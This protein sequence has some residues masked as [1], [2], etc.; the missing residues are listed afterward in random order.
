MIMTYGW[1]DGKFVLLVQE[2]VDGAIV[3]RISM[4]PD[5]AALVAITIK[6][7]PTPLPYIYYDHEQ[8]V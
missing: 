5:E 7:R 2:K 6:A 8:I 4:K 1:C 3:A